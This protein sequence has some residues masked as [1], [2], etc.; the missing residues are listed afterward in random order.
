MMNRILC[1]MKELNTQEKAIIIDC[2]RHR[3]LLD[4]IA[5]SRTARL[6]RMPKILV[7]LLHQGANNK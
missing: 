4:E 1:A 3:H 6:P 2:C 7:L 5:P